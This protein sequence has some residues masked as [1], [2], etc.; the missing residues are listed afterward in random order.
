MLFSKKNFRQFFSGRPS[1]RRAGYSVPAQ[2]Q[3]LQ[4]KVLLSAGPVDVD[5]TSYDETM[6]DETSYDETM[7]DETSYDETMTDET[8]YDETMTDETSYDETMTDETSYDE[9]MTDETTSDDENLPRIGTVSVNAVNG[10]LQV[11]GQVDANGGDLS[12][13]SLEWGEGVSG[14]GLSIDGE[15]GEITGTLSTGTTGTVL[16]RLMRSVDG[17]PATEIDTAFLIV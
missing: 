11:S 17:E 16:L 7:T 2:V 12:G 14:E 9:T 3:T 15:T 6:S 5:E 1:R 13:L 4:N 10:E 8:S